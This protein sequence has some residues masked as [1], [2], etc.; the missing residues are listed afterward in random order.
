MRLGS[1]PKR[2]A[3]SLW[4]R[5][6]T[7]AAPGSRRRAERP[8]DGGAHSHEFEVVGR[9]ETAVELLGALRGRV[10]DVLEAAA[11]HVFKRLDLGLV[12]EELRY[13]EVQAPARAR[14]GGVA[15]LH[16]HQAVD[17]GVH[18]VGVDQD[19]MDDA[20]HRGRGADPQGQGQDGE[21]G[22]GGCLRRPRAA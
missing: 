9:H 21:A 7:G 13:L 20:E 2:F 3:H 19:A 18:R 17:V 6:K 12:V 22:E 1:E 16:L 10:E 4:L 14:L 8:A 11:D 5:T 15:D